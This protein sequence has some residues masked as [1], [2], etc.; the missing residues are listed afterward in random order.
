[1]IVKALRARLSLKLAGTDLVSDREF[2]AV[3]CGPTGAA[4]SVLVWLVVFGWDEAGSG[5]QLSGS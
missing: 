2:D 3:W 1:M 4:S 5:C